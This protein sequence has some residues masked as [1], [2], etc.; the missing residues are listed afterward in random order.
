MAPQAEEHPQREDRGVHN[1]QARARSIEL[2][3]HCGGDGSHG[4]QDE[5]C[6]PIQGRTFSEIMDI[7]KLHQLSDG[8][9]E[10]GLRMLVESVQDLKEEIKDLKEGKEPA[11]KKSLMETP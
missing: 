7:G 6:A 5:A 11:R 2:G 8:S 3:I 1:D 4:L 9:A 10:R